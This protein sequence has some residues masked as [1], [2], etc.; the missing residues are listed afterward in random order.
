MAMGGDKARVREGV[1]IWERG[2]LIV[3]SCPG[4]RLRS[5]ADAE[6]RKEGFVSKKHTWYQMSVLGGHRLDCG[7]SKA[8]S[9]RTGSK[10]PSATGPKLHR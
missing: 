4:A 7:L 3:G 6:K 5:E 10:T 2:L 1:T 9:T 8:E